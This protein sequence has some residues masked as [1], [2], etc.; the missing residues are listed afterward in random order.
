MLQITSYRWRKKIRQKTNKK[1][2]FDAFEKKS[3]NQK[4]NQ[5]ASDLINRLKMLKRH[6]KMIL[7]NLN[8]H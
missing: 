3:V 7:I 8:D 1:N 2:Q 5:T 4:K 6:K